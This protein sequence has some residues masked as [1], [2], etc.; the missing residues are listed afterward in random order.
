MKLLLRISEHY[1][2]FK[3]LQL[4]DKILDIICFEYMILAFDKL[5][6]WTGTGKM[7]MSI[8][9]KEVQRVISKI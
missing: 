3:V 8:E 4:V 2:S 7:K 9:S 1:K 5:V 6:S